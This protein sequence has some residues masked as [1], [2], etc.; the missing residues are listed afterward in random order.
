MPADTILIIGGGP[1]GL[2]A[3]RLI[4]DLGRKVILVE[5]REQLGGTPVA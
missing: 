2:E 3:A 4:G 1:A 5:K